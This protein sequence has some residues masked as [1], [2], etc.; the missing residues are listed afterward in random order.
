[1]K[2]IVIIQTSTMSDE[3]AIHCLLEPM[4]FIPVDSSNHCIIHRNNS[5][6]ALD[7]KPTTLDLSLKIQELLFRNIVRNQ[8]VLCRR[9][10]EQLLT[11]TVP[12]ADVW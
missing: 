8:P 2:V 9:I 1:M 7:L 4:S 11:R 12:N 10:Q 6:T 5:N 3:M